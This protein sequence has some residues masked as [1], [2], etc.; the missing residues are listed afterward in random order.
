MATPVDQ[1]SICA[2]PLEQQGFH[3]MAMPDPYGLK[4]FKGPVL[5]S[6]PDPEE[7]MEALLMWEV[8]AEA[9][10]SGIHQTPDH[11]NYD[12]VPRRTRGKPQTRGKI[13]VFL[14]RQVFVTKPTPIWPINQCYQP[15][16]SFGRMYFSFFASPEF[17]LGPVDNPVPPGSNP[18]GFKGYNHTSALMAYGEAKILSG[19]ATKEFVVQWSTQFHQ[20][21]QGHQTF[22]PMLEEYIWNCWPA[23]AAQLKRPAWE[24]GFQVVQ[25]ASDDEEYAFEIVEEPLGGWQ[26]VDSPLIISLDPPSSCTLSDQLE[27]LQLGGLALPHVPGLLPVVPEPTSLVEQPSASLEQV[28]GANWDAPPPPDP[29]ADP[30]A[31]TADSPRPL[32][33]PNAPRP[34]GSSINGFYGADAKRKRFDG[35]S[36][37]ATNG[38]AASSSHSFMLV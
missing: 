20:L 16:E 31:D 12:L 33:D 5:S 9:Y 11:C 8:P 38:S 3:G 7:V 22:P 36:A 30:N 2:T 4:E 29:D 28:Y 13:N 15:N 35:A 32:M 37:R 21:K 10:P 24:D 19:M 25:Q 18:E 27:E 6:N 17:E 14:R 23:V 34:E 1:S 26:P